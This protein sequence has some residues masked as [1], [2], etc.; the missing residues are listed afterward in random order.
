MVIEQSGSLLFL[1]ETPLNPYSMGM[2]PMKDTVTV[3]HG[4]WSREEE[5]TTQ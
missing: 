3:I 2:Q 1:S 4:S 5:G